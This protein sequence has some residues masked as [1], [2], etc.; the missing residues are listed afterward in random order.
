MTGFRITPSEEFVY[1]VLSIF[2][3]RPNMNRVQ[4]V[5]IQ[6]LN[7][8][9]II[10]NMVSLFPTLQLYYYP[11]KLASLV[12]RDDSGYT[13]TFEACVHILRQVLRASGHKVR[14]RSTRKNNTIDRVIVIV[15]S[16]TS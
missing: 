16:M 8:D 12:T 10:E 9:V 4:E 7:H 14:T 1:E 6:T 11:G 5:H 13:F 15:P 2:L 3:S